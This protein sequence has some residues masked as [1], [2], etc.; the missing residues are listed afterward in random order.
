MA[1]DLAILA[2]LV[3]AAAAEVTHRSIFVM[4]SGSDSSGDGT[5]AKPFAT[6]PAAQQAARKALVAAA[7]GNVTV[8]VGAGRYYLPEPLLLSASDSGRNGGRMRWIGPGPG[9]GVDPQQA[10][11]I[12][13]GVRVDGWRQ[14]GDG[15]VWTADV[16]AL[17][18]RPGSGI[19]GFRRFFNL[20][21]DQRGAVLA[22]HPDFGSG[23][24]KD[25]GCTNNATMLE[26][27]PGVLPRDLSIADTS[28]FANV[29][30]NW[31]TATL[32]AKSTATDAIGRVTVGFQ[33]GA[34]AYAANNKIYIQGAHQLISEPGEW[35]LDS[36][37]T[38]PAVYY[39]PRDTSAM[40]NGSAHI[41][42]NPRD[43][44]LAHCVLDSA[45]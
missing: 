5:V 27:P 31:F 9:A 39:W 29:G 25:V 42:S 34:G 3:T 16:S 23:Y 19:T 1:V 11:I 7:G 38:P 18:S 35:A 26:C 43:A 20:I 2:L 12:H 22:R 15:P 17:A 8:H 37:A 41:V 30:G 14:V 40:Q 6:L 45:F 28:I 24:L 44:S 36:K 4:P 21:E 33:K 32:S 13:G 10:A